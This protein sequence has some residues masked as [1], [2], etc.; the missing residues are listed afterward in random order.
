ML[1]LVLS[2]AQSSYS[3]AENR[4]HHSVAG[5]GA[6]FLLIPDAQKLNAPMQ[7]LQQCS[8]RELLNL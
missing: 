6:G 7:W 4:Q 2:K 3:H 5:S 1:Q 8:V